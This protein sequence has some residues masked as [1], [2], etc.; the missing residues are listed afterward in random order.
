[1]V[2]RS[3]VPRSSDPRSSAPRSASSSFPGSLF[4]RTDLPP[5]NWAA[6][7]TTISHEC[8]KSIPAPT[9]LAPPRQV[10]I[11]PSYGN[12]RCSYSQ[13]RALYSVDKAALITRI[14]IL[15]DAIHYV[16]ITH[17]VVASKMCLLAMK[18]CPVGLLF[19]RAIPAFP[20]LRRRVFCLVV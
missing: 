12:L 20:W 19:L 11:S 6:H 14:V 7:V 17:T 2:P 8:M 16:F 5:F 10:D 3:P 9:C 18:A 1:M 13:F 4:P 15:A